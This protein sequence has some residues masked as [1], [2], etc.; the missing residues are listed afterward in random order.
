MV[1]RS[2]L[3]WP[4][5]STSAFTLAGAMGRRGSW[6]VIA[7]PSFPRHVYGSSRSSVALQVE[8]VDM[9]EVKMW[10][11]RRIDTDHTFTAAGLSVVVESVSR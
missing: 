11:W 6:D 2:R 5:G 4:M 7:S 1:K 3:I 9:F 8:E 10:R